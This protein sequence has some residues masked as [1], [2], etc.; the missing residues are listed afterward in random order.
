MKSNNNFEKSLCESAGLFSLSKSQADLFLLLQ[1]NTITYQQ[2]SLCRLHGN[3]EAAGR[4]SLKKLEKCGYVQSKKIPDTS[5]A[6]Y[7]FLTASGRNYLKELF[8]GT[9]LEQLNI[10]WERRPPGGIQQILHR[11]RTN[12]FYFIYIG[13]PLSCPMP[14]ILEAPLPGCSDLRQGQP[15]RCDGLLIS[16]Y[17]R[18]YIEQ[19]NSTQSESVI[20]Q[21]ICHYQ[22]SGLFSNSENKNLLVFCLAF[23]RRQ[24]P[25]AKPS[26]SL[27]RILLRFTKL[28]ALFEQE[29]KISLDY[30]QFIQVLQSS[31]IHKTISINEMQ[32]LHTLHVLHPEMENLEEA[33]RLKKRYLNDNSYSELQAREA[34][35]LFQKRRHSHF[36]RIF[37]KHPSLL[38][39]ALTGIPLFAVPN[40][41]LHLY[42]PFIMPFE[43]H[44]SEQ[45][46]KCLLYNG[47][48]TD[49]WS[50]HCPLRVKIP[51][52]PDYCFYHGFSHASYGYIAIEHLLIDLSARYRLLHYIKN[53][54]GQD[55]QVLL[56]LV[57]A[58]PEAADIRQ[59]FDSIA[60]DNVK[61]VTTLL[62]ISSSSSL[63]QSPPPHIF[64]TDP[65]K[66]SVLFEC[67][68]FDGKI[69][70]ITKEADP[71]E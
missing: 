71:I 63:Y 42:Q 6:K 17:S 56:I 53:C 65:Q 9:L 12:D 55:R 62:Q 52:E 54:R 31:P 25:A 49:G 29:Y 60:R 27:Y 30:Q 8:P 28:W 13:S 57:S 36:R 34:D 21:K 43:Y 70:F 16:P 33:D 22:Q 15:P 58:D 47:L 10:N 3:T 20:L 37:E 46:L 7:Y 39:Y 41:R 11:I 48:N 64:T 32:A 1:A 38:A 67:D 2:L 35:Q 24:P 40:H 61:N 19:D 14:W 44:L 18:Y 51:N 4:L 69:H 23:P 45:F 59:Q 50:Y 66:Q 5:A 26:F 68:V